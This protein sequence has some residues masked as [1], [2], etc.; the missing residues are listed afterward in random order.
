MYSDTALDVLINNSTFP[1]L[2]CRGKN[3]ILT[4]NSTEISIPYMRPVW[5]DY[6]EDEVNCNNPAF[7]YL[8]LYEKW[9]GGMSQPRKEFSNPHKLVAISRGHHCIARIRELK[10]TN[11]PIPKHV[12]SKCGF[13][14]NNKPPGGHGTEF[15]T[16]L[17]WMYQDHMP[18]LRHLNACKPSAKM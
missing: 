16:F 17:E 4:I 13:Y 15:C 9:S 12:C 2:K 8:E 3:L 11:T 7:V 6:D 5:F 18:H 10:Q 1:E 14:L